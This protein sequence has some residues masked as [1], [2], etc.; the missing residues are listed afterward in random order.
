LTG[1]TAI[2]WLRAWLPGIESVLTIAASE[3]GR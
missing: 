2:G 1:I 3:S